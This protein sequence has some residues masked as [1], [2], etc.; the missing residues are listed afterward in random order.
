VVWLKRS[1]DGGKFRVLNDSQQL[2]LEGSWR[3]GVREKEIE[4][5]TVCENSAC[6]KYV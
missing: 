5:E 1:R 3:A 2:D 6:Q 4:A